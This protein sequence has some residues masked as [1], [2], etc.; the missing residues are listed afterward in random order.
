MSSY[1]TIAT[2]ED[3]GE[4]RLAGGPFTPGTEVE[5]T[6]REKAPGRDEG[7]TA[8]PGRNA[9]KH[10]GALCPRASAEHGVRRATAS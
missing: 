5:V 2:V 4:L 9:R 3:H 7:R 10:E 8:E 6:I 1:A